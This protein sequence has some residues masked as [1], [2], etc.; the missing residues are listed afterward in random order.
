MTDASFDAEVGGEQKG[1][2]IGARPKEYFERE[3][4][5]YLDETGPGDDA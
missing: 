1:S 2:V 5:Q 4:A 3:F